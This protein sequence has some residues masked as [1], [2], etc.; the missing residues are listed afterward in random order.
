MKIYV[1]SSWRN[2]LQPEVV[3][4]LRTAGHEV[5]DFRHPAPG[6]QGFAWSEIDKNWKNWTARQFYNALHH[7]IAQKGFKAD[8]DAMLWAEAFVLVQPCG[9]SA[10]L[11][12]GWACGAGKRTIILLAHQQEA[13]LM[14]K[15]ADFICY[16]MSE[17]LAT[18]ESA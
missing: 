11:Q 5:H 16:T 1:A 7:P 3:S 2:E 13:E 8:F 12:L 17:V 14:Y 15:C 6:D 4:I 18:V 9:R 10:H